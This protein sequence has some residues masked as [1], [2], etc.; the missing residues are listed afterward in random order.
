MQRRSGDCSKQTSCRNISTCLAVHDACGGT[1]EHAGP[2]T[3]EHYIPSNHHA[4]RCAR[5]SQVELLHALALSSSAAAT[6]SCSGHSCSCRMSCC[7]CLHSTPQHHAHALVIPT[8]C[9]GRG[10][11]CR[12]SC[13]TTP[14]SQ[15]PRRSGSRS[16]S[17]RARPAS[18]RQDNQASSKFSTSERALLQTWQ[19]M[20]YSD[21]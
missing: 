1:R 20:C 12:T 17:G 4:Q 3:V 10:C 16:R 6:T 13:C 7:I 5:Q 11:S 19:V 18:R 21:T 9:S 2:Y 8:S 15:A 14:A